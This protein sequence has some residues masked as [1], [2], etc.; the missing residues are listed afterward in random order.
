MS[1]I[2]FMELKCF[3]RFPIYLAKISNFY[4]TWH[5]LNFNFTLIMIYE[6]QSKNQIFYLCPNAAGV[7]KNVLK[8][9]DFRIFDIVWRK[10]GASNDKK[11][12]Q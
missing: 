7:S 10:M 9:G 4:K 3:L 5:S 2:Y 1:L 6:I 8:Q 11:L 12:L